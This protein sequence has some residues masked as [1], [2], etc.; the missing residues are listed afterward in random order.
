MDSYLAPKRDRSQD[1]QLL[2]WHEAN[3]ETSCTFKR[4]LRSS[5]LHD[6]NIKQAG[7]VHDIIWATH[8]TD[9]KGA[10]HALRGMLY[11][12]ET[13]CAFCM[14]VTVFPLKR[15]SDPLTRWSLQVLGVLISSMV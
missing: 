3:G 1:L 8:T 7:G 14:I 11:E 13:L 4:L 2:A 5:D 9:D 6:R 15:Q 12:L 10:K